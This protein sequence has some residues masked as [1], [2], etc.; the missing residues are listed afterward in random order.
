[1]GQRFFDLRTACQD[2]VQCGA[3]ILK[4]IRKFIA[5]QPGKGFLPEIFQIQSACFEL[6]GKRLAGYPG[7]WGQQAAER[8]RGKGFSAPGFPNDPEGLPGIY[9]E[10]YSPQDFIAAARTLKKHP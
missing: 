10:I 8:K 4:N 9:R 5:P 3:G 6:P 1:M 7:R 2:G